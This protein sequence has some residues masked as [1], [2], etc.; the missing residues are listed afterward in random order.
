M[1]SLTSPVLVEQGTMPD[2]YTLAK[3]ENVSPPLQWSGAPEGTRS[4]ALSNVDPDVPWG[5]FGLPPAGTL[6]ADLFVHW[7]AHDIPASVASLPEGAGAPGALPQ[8][9]QNLNNTARDFG[10]GTPFWQHRE[11]WIGCAP[12]AGD[13]AHRYVFTLYALNEASLG[14]SPDA[15]YS[16]FIEALKGKVI[17]TTSLTVY[18]GVKGE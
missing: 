17:A 4:F 16:D 2:K 12:P 14:L 8:G 10:E 1:F 15:H 18:F 9:A 5:S 11:G 3:G 7:V 6:F 13:K